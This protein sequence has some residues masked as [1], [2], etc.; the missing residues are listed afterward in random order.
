MYGPV[1]RKFVFGLVRR[2]KSRRTLYADLHKLLGA[3]TLGWTFVVAGTGLVL[4]VGSLLLQYYSTTELAALGKPYATEAIVT[5]LDTIDRAVA[6][7]E[8]GEPGRHWSIVA[9]P[10]SDL[11][12]P[13][14][15]TVLLQGGKGIE[16]RVLTMALVDAK[17]PA[18]SEAH[19]LPL[20]LR[21]LLLSEPL[22]FGNY[23]GLGLKLIWTLFGLATL[24]LS[25]SGVWSF[26]LGR[27]E[28]RT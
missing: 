21:A 18:R 6:Q 17:D 1:M 19:Q 3:A 15:Y 2:N 11:A 10:G 14:H 8:R 5:D 20:Y 23:G 27:R 12:S 9:L 7:A 4:S 26:W 25:A 22:H 24:V 13:R 28:I 16:A